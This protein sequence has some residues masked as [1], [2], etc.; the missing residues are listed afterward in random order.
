MILS[1]G[2]GTLKDLVEGAI[3]RFK[4]KQTQFDGIVI[5]YSNG[6]VNVKLS[7]GYNMTI[8]VDSMDDVELRGTRKIVSTEARKGKPDGGKKVGLLATGGTIASRVDYVTGAVKPV[9]DPAFLEDSVSNIREFSLD[10]DLMDP[11]LSENLKPNDWVEIARRSLKLLERNGGTI[12]LHGTDTMSYTASALS[13][14]F[15]EQTGPI[16]FVGSQRS[17]DRPS[18]DAFLNLEA[19]LEFSKVPMGEVGVVMH[20]NISD[21]EA[22]LHR[23]VRVRKMH[24]SRRDAFRTLG[25]K[26]MAVYSSGA[27][28]FNEGPSPASERNVL[29][30]KL[31]RKV[32]MVYFH[33][34]LEPDDLGQ[35]LDGRRASIIMGTGL[36]HVGRRFYGII[37]DAVDSGVKVIMTSQCINGMVDMNVYSTGRELQS[38]GVIPAG[39]MLPEV[40]MVKSMHLLGNYPDE[41]FIGLF[42]KNMRGEFNLRD[43]LGDE[44]I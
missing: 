7:S 23:A 18:S 26:P 20:R 1:K 3:L 36:G 38:I 4:Y 5:S 21:H 12:V 37:K 22:A 14:M 24:T 40:A 33:P 31:E 44:P 19:A 28:R 9:L 17:S 32:S 35:M 27:A 43:G 15:Q 10:M 41:D 11:V 42:L 16:L 8:P 25:G 29:M 2:C 30:D 13:F 34:S 39:S 6:L